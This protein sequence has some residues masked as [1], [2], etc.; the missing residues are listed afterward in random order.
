MHTHTF[1]SF[2]IPLMLLSSRHW[3]G[4]DYRAGKTPGTN[5]EVLTTELRKTPWTNTDVLTADLVKT[6]GTNRGSNY[7]AG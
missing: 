6:T 3:R 5:T 7:R 1:L 4:S 2:E